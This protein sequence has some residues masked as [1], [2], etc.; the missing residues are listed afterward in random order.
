MTSCLY[1]PEVNIRPH[2]QDVAEHNIKHAFGF[3][4]TRGLQRSCVYVIIYNYSI[5]DTYHAV[6][7]AFTFVVLYHMDCLN[8]TVPLFGFVLT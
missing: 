8:H 1:E 7:S 6:L 5:N 4:I 2:F 3:H